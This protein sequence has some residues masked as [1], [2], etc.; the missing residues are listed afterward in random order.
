MK[1]PT[2]ERLASHLARAIHDDIASPASKAKEAALKIFD[3]LRVRPVITVDPAQGSYSFTFV[4]SHTEED[5]DA[6][7]ERLLELPAQ[8]AAEQKVRVVVYFDEFQEITDIDPKLPALMRAVF[9]EQPDIA[10]VYAGSKRDM[11]SRLFN[12][13][14]EAFYRSA[15]VMEIGAI[16]PELFTSFIKERFDATGRASRTRRSRAC[17]RSRWAIRTRPRSLPT[18]PWDEVPP[19][20]S[21]T[22]SDLERALDAVLRS[23]NAR[24]TLLWDNLSRAQRQLLQALADEPGHV[25]SMKYLAR[26]GLPS[27]RRCRRRPGARDRRADRRARGRESVR[28]SCSARPLSARLLVCARPGRR[29]DTGIAPLLRLHVRDAPKGRLA[30]RRPGR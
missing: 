28:S 25:Q 29:G 12:D 1:A 19:G 27:A 13:K 18:P 24:F 2:K 11:M 4:A 3:S 15:K 14:N 7:I 21:A 8:L 20:F 16:A 5:I 23:E 22:V 30:R 9:Q 10:H 26:H 6:T 17:S